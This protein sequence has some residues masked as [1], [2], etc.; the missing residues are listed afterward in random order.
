[1]F[2]LGRDNRFCTA[3]FCENLGATCLQDRRLWIWIYPWIF[4]EKLWIWIWMGDFKPANSRSLMKYCNSCVIEFS[5]FALC[6]NFF[7]AF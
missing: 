6:V 3:V 5:K 2:L 1:M 7:N 4:M